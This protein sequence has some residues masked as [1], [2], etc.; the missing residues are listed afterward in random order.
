[1]KEIIAIIRMNK[2]GATKKALVRVGVAGFTAF[3]VD[4]RG[5]LVTDPALIE[6]RKKELLL[7]AGDDETGEAKQIINDFLDGTKLFPRR[8]FTILAHDEE[9]DGIVSAIIEANRT[10]NNVGDGKILILPVFDAVRVR[11]GESGE[12]AV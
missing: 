3:K 8:L 6:E 2:T 10:T 12:S 1:M 11:T 4:G 5:R 9:V 7:L